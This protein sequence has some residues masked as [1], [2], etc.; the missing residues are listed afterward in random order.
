ML[1]HYNN[2]NINLSKIIKT[3]EIEIKNLNKKKV[4]NERI[5]LY[6]K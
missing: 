6:L 3:L 5:I 1:K 4:L 2:I